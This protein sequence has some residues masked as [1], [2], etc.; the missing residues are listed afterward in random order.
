MVKKCNNWLELDKETQDFLIGEYLKRTEE[1]NGDG[2]EA[3]RIR[4]KKLAQAAHERSVGYGIPANAEKI[5]SQ[6][7]IPNYKIS[8]YS[9]SSQLNK[10]FENSVYETLKKSSP[11]FNSL[12]DY[13]YKTDIKEE[14]EEPQ[15]DQE[16]L[17]EVSQERPSEVRKKKVIELKS[18]VNELESEVRNLNKKYPEIEK[19]FQDYIQ[20]VP[21]ALT[22]LQNY[23]KDGNFRE[24][25]KNSVYNY[26]KGVCLESGMDF[27]SFYNSI[28]GD[29]LLNES[30][31]EVMNS[32]LSNSKKEFKITKPS[33]ERAISPEIKITKPK[34]VRHSLDSLVESNGN[35]SLGNYEPVFKLS[36]EDKDSFKYGCLSGMAP[37][38]DPLGYISSLFY[39]QI[40]GV[41]F[42]D[43][44][45]MGTVFNNIYRSVY[46]NKS[47][48]PYIPKSLG[49][50]TGI[51]IAA[52]SLIGLSLIN[53][54]LGLAL[55]AI[56]GLYSIYKTIKKSF[57]NK[58]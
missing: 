30:V 52:G 8:E 46:K 27:D 2:E 50:I 36:K 7:L 14:T 38:I 24:D 17:N 49:T 11:Q 48:A 55:P 10:L 19:T 18:R 53:P 21:G 5:Y 13:V 40:S 47:E 44:N 26:L 35:V 29:K 4:A 12:F 15:E 20:G 25:M 57:S 56:T 22:K 9:P 39:R 23:L 51:G 42:K 6:K 45:S 16:V 43:K 58:K 41:E 28:G 32:P 31:E 33:L 37:V 54:L 1:S 34:N 3:S